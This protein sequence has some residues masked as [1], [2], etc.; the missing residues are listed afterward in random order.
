MTRRTSGAL[1]SPLFVLTLA[2]TVWFAFSFML[3]PAARVV[4]TV[5][6]PDGTASL[7]AFGR[8]FASD[9]A[10]EA[11]QHSFLLA[12]VLSVTVNVVG[13]ALVLFTRYFA[14][15]GGRVLWLGYATT[16]I[17][18]GIVL[19]AGYKFVYGE[20]GVVTRIAVGL[21][22]GLDPQ[23]FSGMTAVVLVMTFA[24]T[25]NHLLFLGNALAK[26]DHQT[27]EAA[28]LMGAS[29][30]RVL[31]T[32]VLPTLMPTI[33]ALTILTFLGGLGALAAPQVL[34]GSEFQTIAPMIF[35]FAGAA[36]SRD[37]AAALA[38]VL[39]VATVT[40]LA[41]FSRLER[42]GTYFSVSKV[43]T[44]QQLR[45]IENPLAAALAHVTAY[46]LFAVYVLPPILIVL[47]SFADSAAI[48]SAKLGFSSLTLDNYARVLG[49]YGQLWPFLVSVGYALAATT[50]VVA[51]MLVV[52]R[53][54]QL[55]PG[56][57]TASLELLLHIPWM[58]PAVMLALGLILL[59]DHD[60]PLV[61]GQVLTGTVWLLLI[62]Y[63][64]QRIPFTLRLL[65][66]A[67]AGV[68]DHLDDAA[69][70]LGANSMHT[71]RRVLFPAVAPVAAAIAAV[72]FTGLLDDYD[73]S[74]F[75]AHPLYQPIGIVIKNAT[76][77]DTNYDT[78]ATTFVYTVLL[79]TISALAMW[80]IYGR[81]SRLGGQNRKQKW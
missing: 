56:P 46:A 77:N 5:F 48:Q 63:V 51:L 3:A 69:R 26:V 9:R 22:P 34:G 80:L 14:I 15:R 58:L 13:I 44:M 25:S 66:A 35:D 10:V 67:Y 61:G 68:P 55:Y 36:G 59:Y 70:L 33:Y 39:G 50:I 17:Y 16:L 65:K 72:N 60:N 74:I 24:T 54:I 45:R 12:G 19:V 76:E 1:R 7:G 73:T 31:R 4:Q 52:A 75:L 18:G 6:F 28:R 38:L 30:A 47:F 64:A 81:G 40:L 49:D 42:G 41:V 79:M 21:W 8:L 62:A 20:R 2:G 37:L 71:F 11:L 27:I 78:T 32:V 23:W 43:P 29:E 57:F 53:V